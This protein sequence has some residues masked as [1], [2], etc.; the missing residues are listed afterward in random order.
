MNA[1]LWAAGSCAFFW[2][3][4]TVFGQSK[5]DLSVPD[6]FNLSQQSKTAARPTLDTRLVPMDAPL[7]PA[8]YT[9][10]PGDILSLN[11]WSA[12]P[13][14]HQ[15]QVTPEG[16]LLVPNVGA[17]SIRD[18]TLEAVRKKVLPLI[19]KKFPG[20]EV[21]LTLLAPR[22]ISVQISGQVMSEGMQEMSSVQRVDH[23]ITTA[24]ALAPTQMTRD[25]YFY[26]LPKLK[27]DA[28]QR[29]IVVHRRDG[30]IRH[31]DLLKYAVTG[32]SQYDPYLREGDNIYVPLRTP[33]DNNVGVL[34][35]FLG[36]T[37]VEYA[38]GDS[39]TDLVA[40][41]FGLKPTADTG[42]AVLARETR[43]GGMD[44]VRFDLR[45]VLQGRAPNIA[46][47]PGDRLFVPDS[48]DPRA[49]DYVTIEGEVVHPGRYPITA[50][51]TRIR[52]VIRAAGGFTMNANP[53]AATLARGR[54][55]ATNIPEEIQTEQL[56]STRTAIL[57]Q[58]S[59]Y[60]LIETALRLRGEMVSVNFRKL[61]V[62]GDTTFDVTMRNYDHLTIPS[63]QRTVYV[64]GQVLQPGHVGYVPGE[65]YRY[66]IDKANGYTA[67][68]RSSD[69]KVIKAGSR[70]W[71]DPGE[72]A[73]ED[74][75]FIWVPKDYH[76]PF[77]YYLT[78]AVQIA[79]ILGTLAT[80]YILART[81]K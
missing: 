4:A 78:T 50:S 68:A 77:G 20:A 39:I 59:S 51:A 41:G 62:E 49:G 15:L 57:P 36:P 2:L 61:F 24:N 46:V 13:S 35:A 32:K 9:V 60:Y 8:E 22:K 3:A 54:P 28:S 1:R 16:I 47:E 44:T 69:V 29:N 37:N 70:I 79:G 73:I 74:G 66:Y 31:V 19:Q 80:F 81:I 75:D 48:P 45:A 23:L 64:F 76:L 53:V 67:D 65:G 7:D 34:G 58:D 27:R 40:M 43:A 38:E 17:I 63:R 11:I 42:H 55:Y 18:L 14:D 33:E 6:L 25:F 56:M 26:D 5:M 71:L 21:S 10:G 30:S 72:T 52:D 12:A